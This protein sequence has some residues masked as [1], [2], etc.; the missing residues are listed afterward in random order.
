MDHA[1]LRRSTHQ[2]EL[3]SPPL[4]MRTGIAAYLEELIRVM[5]QGGETS[6][7]P[8]E[9]RKTVANIAGFLTSQARGS[10][11]VDLPVPPGSEPTDG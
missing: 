8:R 6:S 4:H 2:A 9:A 1:M 10:A 11:R 5:E 7:S 3:L